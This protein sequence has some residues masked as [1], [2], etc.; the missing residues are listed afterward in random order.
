MWF[1]STFKLYD[2]ADSLRGFELVTTKTR[3]AVTRRE[4]LG[5]TAGL[6]ATAILLDPR[7]ELAPLP[8]IDTHQHLWDLDRFKLPWLENAKT[9][10]RSFLMSDYLKAVQDLNVVKSIYMEVDVHVS[11]QLAEAREVM[12]IIARGDTPMVG[13]VISGRPNSDNFKSYLDHFQG[14][15]A[16]KGLRQVLHSKTTPQ[17]Y[18]LEPK[19]IAGIK[20]LGDRNLSF[21]LCMRS[22]ELADAAKLVD[23]C[24]G[25]TFILDHCG[26]PNVQS[27]DRSQWKQDI[28]SLAKR[29]NVTAKISGIV[30]SAKAGSWTADDLAPIIN[31]VIDAFGPDRVVFGGDWPVCTLTATYRQWVEALL[32]VVKDRPVDVQ[33]KLLHDN[34]IRVYK[35]A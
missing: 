30:A 21:D 35:L 7:A 8:I 4:F 26:N 25:T 12:S 10:D 17:G 33:K 3:N 15:P 28:L 16:I 24:P 1:R 27:A 22:S 6:A 19:F 5:E 2:Q 11:Q 31:H 18:C 34:A 23:A 29:P 14:K 9:L 20:L 13:A 32:Q